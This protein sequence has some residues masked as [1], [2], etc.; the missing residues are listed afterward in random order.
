[1]RTMRRKV[2]MS[3]LL[4]RLRQRA[5]LT[6][7]RIFGEAAEALEA[8]LRE[9]DEANRRYHDI[10]AAWLREQQSEPTTHST[11]AQAAGARRS[12]IRSAPP[13]APSEP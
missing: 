8:A 9:R 5:H 1:M 12:H 11:S 2:F 10:C 13:G 6:E 3:D 4:T 7:Y